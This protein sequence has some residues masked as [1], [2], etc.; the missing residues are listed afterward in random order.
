MC[1][2]TG[3]SV[4]IKTDDNLKK[5]SLANKPRDEEYPSLD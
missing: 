1:V 4:T 2:L 5:P 3:D